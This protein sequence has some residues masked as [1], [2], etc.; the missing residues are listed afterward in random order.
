MTQR[1]TENFARRVPD[2]DDHERRICNICGFID[3][4]NP[5]IVA[6]SVVVRDRKILLCRR[7]IEPRKGFWTLPAG[8]MELGESIE[9]AGMRE[10]QEEACAAIAIDRVLAMYTVHRIGQV[11]IMFRANL[12]SDIHPGPESIEVGLFDWKDIPWSELA[13]PTVVWALTH[14]AESR[15]SDSFA[16]YGNPA[17]TERITRQPPVPP[18][19]V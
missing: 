6:G 12:V 9:E 13:F 15:H 1:M 8:Y 5:R 3:Y 11:Q 16:P 7:A 18:A 17:G 4:E 19:G 14:Y 10:A 2:G